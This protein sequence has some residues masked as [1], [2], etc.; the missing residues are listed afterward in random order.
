MITTERLTLRKFS[1]GDLEDFA[2]LM[3]DPEVMRFSLK[4][5]LSKDQA[6]EYLKTRILAHYEKYGFGLWAVIFEGHLIGL[7]GL[8]MQTIDGQEEVE[9]AYRLHPRYWGKGLATEAAVAICKYAFETLAVERLISIIDPQNHRSRKVAER[10]GMHHWKD[11]VYHGFASHIYA[12]KK[13]V[14]SL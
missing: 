1:E 3:A 8:I 13:V 9:V 14:V 11:T 10:M 2:A 12:L 7:A 4:G 5:P 6:T